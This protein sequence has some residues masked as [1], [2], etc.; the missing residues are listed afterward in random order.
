MR[1]LE[2]DFQQARPAAAWAGWALLALSLALGAD[3]ARSYQDAR[4]AGARLE[5][6]LAQAGR[7]GGAQ[8]LRAT[9][10][11]LQQAREAILRLSLPWEG[12][13]A[14]LEA[15]PTGGVA[16]LAIAPDAQSGTALISGTG[17]DVPAVLDYVAALARAEA[18]R[19]VRLVKH[20]TRRGAGPLPVAF[21][22]SVAWRDAP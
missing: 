4:E 15:A 13:F 16:L 6:R 2:L 21:A 8:P 22:I 5:V 12:L 20:E 11:E 10:A 7:A 19:R 3:L 1:R 17:R 14:A 9:A 18:L